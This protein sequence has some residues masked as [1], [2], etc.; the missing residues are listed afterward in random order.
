[1]VG[2]VERGIS[3]AWLRMENVAWDA[4]Y[5]VVAAEGGE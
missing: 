5:G 2:L 3:V 4:S 1:M